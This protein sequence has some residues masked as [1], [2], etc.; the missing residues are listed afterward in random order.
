MT[1][2]D[3]T[4]TA[5][6]YDVTIPR[7]LVHKASVAE[8]F[9]TDRRELAP[10]RIRFACDLPRTHYYYND[11]DGFPPRFDAMTLLEACRQVCYFVDYSCGAT[12]DHK[13]ILRSIELH[14]DPAAFALR[15]EHDGHIAIDSELKRTFERDG[16]TTGM[17]VAFELATAAGA[18]LAHG[19][20]SASW[21]T[22]D[23]W[24]RLRERGRAAHGLPRHATGFA[25]PVR[26]AA[27]ALVGRESQRNVVIGE[28]D[29]DAL[30][31]GV[32]V[33]MT[34]PGLFDHALDHISGM[35][36][37]E[38]ARQMAIWAASRALATPAAGLVVDRVSATY[39]AIGEL[40]LPT[41]ATARL[42]GVDPPSATVDVEVAQGDHSLCS[43]TVGVTAAA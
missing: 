17:Q 37:I 16:A 2:T 20:E 39:S 21:V 10:G 32:V 18:P 40:E 22:A 14:I 41:L 7:R 28:L 5:L 15:C 9:I 34:H 1:Q 31:A 25:P 43:V 13:F 42:A 12:S 6:S 27:P 8:V 23:A 19:S 11:L 38:A 26:P 24:E 36:Q 33:D 3:E 30:T 35:V 4:A 29:E